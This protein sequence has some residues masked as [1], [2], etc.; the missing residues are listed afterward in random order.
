MAIDYTKKT[1]ANA[2]QQ[3]GYPH[4]GRPK[5]LDGRDRLDLRAEDA[6]WTVHSGGLTS[7]KVKKPDP[8]PPVVRTVGMRYPRNPAS[9]AHPEVAIHPAPACPVKGCTLDRG[10]NQNKH[11]GDTLSARVNTPPRAQRYRNRYYRWTTQSMSLRAKPSART[12]DGGDANRISPNKAARQRLLR[13][14]R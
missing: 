5:I 13:A 8:V 11:G 6:G 4:V 14:S 2:E 3:P 7:R 1:R 12:E 10:H 9:W